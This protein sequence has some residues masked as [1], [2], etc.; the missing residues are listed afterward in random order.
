MDT[1]LHHNSTS[2]STYLTPPRSAPLHGHLTPSLQYI[3]LH[4]PYLTKEAHP[5]VA[6][7]P[8][9]HS[10]TAHIFF[11]PLSEY[12]SPSSQHSPLLPTYT[13]IAV[14]TSSITSGPSMQCTHPPSPQPVHHSAASHTHLAPSVT[15][16]LSPWLSITVPTTLP[17]RTQHHLPITSPSGHRTPHLC[18]APIYPLKDIRV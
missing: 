16:P 7:S 14:H 18:C 6:T 17:P 11:T 12:T 2:V 4:P 15:A 1:S 10:I 5:S 9:H 13:I 8:P 3:P